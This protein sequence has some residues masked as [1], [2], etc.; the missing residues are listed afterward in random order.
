MTWNNIHLLFH[1]SVGRKSRWPWQISQGRNQGISRIVFFSGGS[2]E[3]S[4]SKFIQVLS[5]TEFLLVVG[6][7]APFSY[8]LL[9]E[10]H[11]LQSG[12][13]LPLSGPYPLGSST[14]LVRSLPPMSDPSHVMNRSDFSLGC[15]LKILYFL[16]FMWLHWACIC[17]LPLLIWT[18]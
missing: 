6:L 2:W 8:W 9:A 4:A 15:Q 1:S 10:D 13:T 5:R 16:G 18:E 7:R 11:S 12:R 17:N 3:E 14:W